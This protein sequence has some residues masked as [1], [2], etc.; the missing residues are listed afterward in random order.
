LL[1][2]GW[3]VVRVSLHVVAATVWVGGQL[4]LAGLVGTLRDVGGEAPKRVARRFSTIAWPAYAILL[5]TGIWDLFAVHLAGHSLAWKTVLVVKL[6][7]VL[8]SGMAAWLHSRAKARKGLAVWG[9]LTGLSAVAALV[10][11]VALAG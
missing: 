1:A 10:L 2:P 11:G 4:T 9:A 5:A 3:T 6:A 8:L 7:V